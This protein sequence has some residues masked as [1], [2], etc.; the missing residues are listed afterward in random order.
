MAVFRSE[1]SHFG[2]FR[3]RGGHTLSRCA[4]TMHFDEGAGAT[5]GRSR[6]GHL[7]SDGAF[8]KLDADFLADFTDKRS[9]QGFPRL[10]FAAG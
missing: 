8:G 4:E 6:N 1:P 2:D 7:G 5:V 3:G 10:G 9:G